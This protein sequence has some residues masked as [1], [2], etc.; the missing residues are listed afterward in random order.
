MFSRDP[1]GGERALCGYLETAALCPRQRFEVNER[2]SQ[3]NTK[4]GECQ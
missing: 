4:L 1:A 2:P 3:G